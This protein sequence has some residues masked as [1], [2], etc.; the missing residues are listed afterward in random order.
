MTSVRERAIASAEAALNAW[1]SQHM[2]GW[3][4]EIASTDS[5]RGGGALSK[6]DRP[7]WSAVGCWRETSTGI[8]ISLAV[9]V[10]PTMRESARGL[11]T[12]QTSSQ[13]GVAMTGEE[14]YGAPL[15][16]DGLAPRQPIDERCGCGRCAARLNRL[17]IARVRYGR[18]SR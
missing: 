1:A 10:W 15:R 16:R 5:H 9:S 4:A 17:H 7:S 6:Y 18:A 12:E 8:E 11:A 2:P 14:W 13:R 3:R